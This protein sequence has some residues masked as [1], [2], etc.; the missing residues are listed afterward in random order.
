MP[1]GCMA[2]RLAS[3]HTSP[4][5]DA[6]SPHACQNVLNSGFGPLGDAMAP[7]KEAPLKTTGGHPL[8]GGPV[9]F[10]PHMASIVA[11]LLPRLQ[12]WAP[13]RWGPSNQYP[14]F[15]PWAPLTTQRPPPREARSQDHGW[16]PSPGWP[17]PLSVGRV[18]AG[19]LALHITLTVCGCG[20]PATSPLDP[21]S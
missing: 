2:L 1:R 18:C 21:E 19:P 15:W 11:R 7:P 17:T 12:T 5:L 6:L 9:A 4:L 10:V 8:Q 13:N 16:L 14:R 3:R 20:A